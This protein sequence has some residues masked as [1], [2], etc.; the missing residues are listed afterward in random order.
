M[1]QDAANT[2]VGAGAAQ[3]ALLD[4]P[5]TGTLPAQQTALV[6]GQPGNVGNATSGLNV[7]GLQAQSTIGSAGVVAESQGY[8]VGANQHVDTAGNTGTATTATDARLNVDQSDAHN[9]GAIANEQAVVTTSQSATVTATAPGGSGQ[10]N[11]TLSAEG[12][13]I[14]QVN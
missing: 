7:A 2:P 13:Q 3:S 6:D 4:R 14:Q 1:S 11:N 12:I 8:T 9:V 10:V 5:G